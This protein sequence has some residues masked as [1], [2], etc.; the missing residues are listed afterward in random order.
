M[1]G[2]DPLAPAPPP[3]GELP[4]EDGGLPLVPVVPLPP[5]LFDPDVLLLVDVCGDEG[6]FD[7]AAPPEEE[8]EPLFTFGVELSEPVALSFVEVDPGSVACG[9]VVV[10]PS[11]GC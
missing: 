8:L 6:L 2:V 11:A 1:R 7:G 3:E 5:E 10:S 4:A 9:S